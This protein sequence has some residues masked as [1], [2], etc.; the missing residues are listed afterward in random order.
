MHSKICIITT[1]HPAFDT[2]IFVRGARSLARAGYCVH[3]VAQH[4]APETLDGVSV[5]ALRKARTRAMR[6]A[7]LGWRAFFVALRTQADV[8]HFHDPEFMVFGLLLHW[9]RRKPVIYDA[10]EDLPAQILSKEWIPRP[11][12]R[13]AARLARAGLT[14]ALKRM[15]AVVAA[16]EGVADSLGL[17]VCPVVVRNFPVLDVIPSSANRGDD[18]MIR[19]AYLG[20]VS[21]ERGLLEMLEA[22]QI[23]SD[24]P[25]K[26]VLQGTAT[27][28]A[29]RLLQAASEL[30]RV[31]YVPWAPPQDACQML[32]SADI[33]LVCLRP[34]PRFQEALP[35]KLFEYMAAGIAVIASDFPLWREIVGG[36]RCGLLVDPLDP[37][38]I[39]EAMRYLLDHPEERATMGKNGRVAVEREYN[40]EAESAKLLDLY[41]CVLGDQ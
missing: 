7:F 33:G 9:I 25:I 15:C 30:E 23:L 40:W 22:M 24:E 3:L 28:S 32:A 21:E 4:D 41:A 20:R 27:P 6:F 36:A 18:G 13:S 12:R 1:A 11:L 34:V 10:H 17:P 2:R 14:F 8:Y 31:M 16:T 38:S 5:L 19:V 26:L 37:W 35:V 39:A 29:K